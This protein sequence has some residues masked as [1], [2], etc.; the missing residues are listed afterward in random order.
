[1]TLTTRIH[2]VTNREPAAYHSELR[3]AVNLN[4]ECEG[5][6]GDATAA[7]NAFGTFLDELPSVEFHLFALAQIAPVWEATHKGKL[8][9]QPVPTTSPD[10]LM[11]WLDQARVLYKNQSYWAVPP[12]VNAILGTPGQVIDISRLHATHLL[13]GSHAWSAP[14]AHR[15]GLTRLLSMPEGTV[16]V[17]DSKSIFIVL[18]LAG[19]KVPD[20]LT[21][22]PLASD[23]SLWELT[24]G[25]DE[26]EGEQK[27]APNAGALGKII[28]RAN[29]L[30]PAEPSSPPFLASDG[31]LVVNPDAGKLRR[32]LDW[33]EQS[34]AGLLSGL[35]ALLAFDHPT[36]DSDKPVL[37][38]YFAPQW[39]RTDDGQVTLNA[40]NA[41]WRMVA[42]LV[43][44]LDPIVVALL[45]PP[46]GATAGDLLLPLVNDILDAAQAVPIQQLNLTGDA[47]LLAIRQALGKS[48]FLLGVGQKKVTDYINAMRQIHGIEN[49]RDAANIPLYLFNMLLDAIDDTGKIVPM[50]FAIKDAESL[51]LRN[52]KG[53]LTDFRGDPYQIVIEATHRLHDEAGAEDVILRLFHSAEL[54]KSFPELIWDGLGAKDDGSTAIKTFHTGLTSVWNAFVARLN[55]PF[56]AEEATRRSASAHFLEALLIAAA[57][58]DTPS[59]GEVPPPADVARLKEKLTSADLFA[60]RCFGISGTGPFNDIIKGLPGLL[61]GLLPSPLPPGLKSSLTAAYTAVLQPLDQWTE[62]APIF[63]SDDAPAPLP[64]QVSA[65]IGGAD[66]DTFAKEFNGICVALRRIDDPA[67]RDSAPWAYANLAE[68]RLWDGTIEGIGLRQWMPALHDQRAPMFIDYQGYPFS[69][70]T[71]GRVNAPA[72]TLPSEQDRA[73]THA[74]PPFYDSA[75]VDFEITKDG[76]TPVPKLVYGRCFEAFSF[77]TTS[78]GSVPKALQKSANAPWDPTPA[79]TAPEKAACPRVAYQRRTAIGATAIVELD[80]A[81]G[82]KRI[83]LAIDGVYPL[84]ADYPRVALASVDGVAQSIDLLREA[85]GEGALTFPDAGSTQESVWV[86]LADGVWTGATATTL[87]VEFHDRVSLT[88]G[89]DPVALV[90]KDVQ[91]PQQNDPHIDIGFALTKAGTFRVRIGSTELHHD[92]P[93]GN[94]TSWWIR[95]TLQS[96]DKTCLSFADP[97]GAARQQKRGPPLLL[98][99]PS[100]PLSTWM[101]QTPPISLNTK[102]VPPRAGFVDF[103]RWFANVDLRQHT[104]PTLGDVRASSLLDVLLLAYLR[105]NEKRPLAS[106]VKSHQRKDDGLISAFLDRLPDPAVDTLLVELVRLDGIGA[107]VGTA[108]SHPLDIRKRIEA[109]ATTATDQ[110]PDFSAITLGILEKKVFSTLTPDDWFKLE[111]RSDGSDLS[112]VLLDDSGLLANVPKGVVAELRISPL[113]LKQRF[114]DGDHPAVFDPGMGQLAREYGTDWLIFPGDALRI[115]TIVDDVKPLSDSLR[116]M[117]DAYVACAPSASVRAYSLVSG[118]D[119]CQKLDDWRLIG[120]IAVATQRWRSGGRPIYTMIDPGKVGDGSSGTAARPVRKDADVTDAVVAF[121]QEIFAGRPTSEVQTVWQ[122]LAPQAPRVDR[123]GYQPDSAAGQTVL[124]TFPF[125]SPAATYLRHRYQVRTRYTGALAQGASQTLNGWDSKKDSMDWNQRV[126]MLADRKRVL[127]TRPQLRALIPLTTSPH[128]AGTPPVMAFLQEPPFS[129][130]GLADRIASELKLGFGFGFDAPQTTP[131]DK[132]VADKPDQDQVQILD[133]RKEFGPDPRLTYNRMPDDYDSAP[134]DNLREVILAAEGPIG[135]TFDSTEATASVFAFANTMVSM[136]PQSVV[137]TAVP[138]AFEEHFLGIAMRRYLDP[139]WLTDSADGSQQWPGAECR[140]IDFGSAYSGQSTLIQY[141]ERTEALLSFDS[142][143]RRL[144]VAVGAIDSASVRS[145]P[146]KNWVSIAI[147]PEPVE[148][149]AMLHVPIAPGRYSASVFFQRKKPDISQ[150]ETNQPVMLASF[151]WSPVD[152]SA[153]APGARDVSMSTTAGT[154]HRCV[155]SAPTF[156]AWTRTSRNFS[157]VPIA[158]CASAPGRTSFDADQLVMQIDKTAPPPT[159]NGKTPP[160]LLFC[161]PQ[162]RDTVV[163]VCPRSSTFASPVPI[164]V[165]RHLAVIG[166]RFAPGMGKPLEVFSGSVMLRELAPNVPQLPELQLATC[167]RLVEFESPASI[168]GAAFCLDATDTFGPRTATEISP[169]YNTTYVDFKS[170]GATWDRVF[171]ILIRFVGSESH[172]QQFDRIG[173]R[174]E[175]PDEAPVDGKASSSTVDIMVP[176]KPN[177]KATAVAC[178]LVLKR[179]AND[180]TN[181]HIAVTPFCIF[182]DGS[183]LPF[184]KNTQFEC[185]TD[186]FLLSLAVPGEAEFWTDVSVLHIDAARGGA[187]ESGELVKLDFDLLFSLPDKQNPD[188]LAPADAVQPRQLAKMRE[189]QARIVSVSPPIAVLRSLADE[190]RR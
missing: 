137:G 180:K 21:A 168:L 108:F 156:L 12:D 172:L 64:I 149:V 4:L 114:Q 56:N 27:G 66:M 178:E 32:L 85:G 97:R 186:G 125:D 181:T 28:C 104:F 169:P 176:L 98:M 120:E 188:P 15:R 124:Q 134:N 46:S 131:G 49:T 130:G 112:L 8:E 184:A 167:L 100:V 20:V 84:S 121:E 138:A 38:D 102:I 128:H 61:T 96:S 88:G 140:W 185:T 78:S 86:D 107:P 105:R 116:S 147:V 17:T 43:T 173:V 23:K 11:K 136:T 31:Y 41:V 48:P 34:W 117:I 94:S 109:W 177:G 99:A 183:H 65:L 132:P 26:Q 127:V 55:G 81:P 52:E 182:D 103:E 113:V 187:M 144:K 154:A 148:S 155:A 166:T 145:D 18:P 45:R 75:E 92:N 164:H 37:K 13:R 76:W 161:A 146:D 25:F 71:V 73:E 153:N 123:T 70:R 179:D 6:S 142:G 24:Y 2:C 165:H 35:P 57:Q 67:H 115:E 139:A 14:I 152:A 16:D 89:G 68:F 74:L 93:R 62:A 33:F 163:T 36:D 39:I 90:F 80:A 7:R 22:S 72:T 54:D 119:A 58:P 143:T 42:G 175:H 157:K 111:I 159:G 60:Q 91:P 189:V 5:D 50:T 135:L 101:Q 190:H 47:V 170:T 129:E 158:P 29:R 162:S 53:E 77:A 51:A 1:M 141:G 150:G 95:L 44:A 3:Y 171:R 79:P 10:S 151:E 126:M 19:G 9:V 63:K 106:D 82:P 174:L 30:N 40:S 133:A 69:S 87:T 160:V 59:R 110:M 122:R 83:G 118:G